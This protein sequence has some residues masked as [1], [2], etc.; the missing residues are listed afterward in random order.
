MERMCGDVA[1]LIQKLTIIKQNLIV[2]LYTPD[3]WGYLRRQG[4]ES[5][6]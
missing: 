2:F 4:F 6:L 5:M 1:K 3:T